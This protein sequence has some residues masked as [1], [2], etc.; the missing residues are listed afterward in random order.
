MWDPLTATAVRDPWHANDRGVSALV[1]LP[2]RDGGAL[3]A[4]SGGVDGI[5]G[6]WNPVA[7][8]AVG[9]CWHAPD[10]A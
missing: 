9:Q 4:V 7:G 6:V 3:L 5:V 8:T 2:R 1:V 10:R